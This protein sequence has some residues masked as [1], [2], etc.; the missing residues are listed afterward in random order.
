MNWKKEIFTTNDGSTTFY[1]PEINEYYHSHHGAIQEAK[2]VFLKNGLLFNDKL[3]EIKILEIGFGT[4]LNAF[5]TL[6]ES[7]NKQLEYHTIEAYP[8][9]S[10]QI[11]QLNFVKLINQNL[12]DLFHKIHSSDWEKLQ[13]ITTSFLLKKNKLKIQDFKPKN[14][15]YDLIYFDAFGPRV[16]PEMWTIEIFKKMFIFLKPKGILVTYC[17][18][19]QVK[20]D[21][22]S[23]G[24][25]V[26]TL[27]GP[28][29][30]REMI[31]AIRI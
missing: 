6:L 25:T 30:K 17:A 1:L 7:K 27:A 8:L 26:E 10:E 12:L 24:F 9:N 4:G 13:E 23:V 11:A 31:R 22:K 2:H 21:L 19:G 29:G 28:P 16:Q 20:R 3:K 15:F 18:K 5:L 14:Q